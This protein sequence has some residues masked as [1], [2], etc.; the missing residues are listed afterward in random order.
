MQAMWM[1]RNRV[2]PQGQGGLADYTE[3]PQPAMAAAVSMVDT[4]QPPELR[5]RLRAVTMSSTADPDLARR[6]LEGY[7]SV[8]ESLERREGLYTVI[9]HAEGAEGCLYKIWC[10]KGLCNI[11]DSGEGDH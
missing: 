7:L 3:S 4:A 5:S 8:R 10:P 6:M 1:W 11:A 9:G 2:F